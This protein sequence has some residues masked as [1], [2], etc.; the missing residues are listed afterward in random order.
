MLSTI[1]IASILC[2]RH[3]SL[4][5]SSHPLTW[6]SSLPSAWIH[7]NIVY[8]WAQKPFRGNSFWWL[9]TEIIFFWSIPKACEH[10]W[11]LVHRLTGKF[12]FC[13]PAQLL[14][15]HNS[16]EQRSHH[17]WC[18][19]D[20]PVELQLTLAREQDPEIPEVLHSQPGGSSALFYCI[21][22]VSNYW[23]QTALMMEVKVWLNQQNHIC[24]RQRSNPEVPKLDNLLPPPVPWDPVH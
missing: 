2:R 16:L 13:L 6:W 24:K 1:T 7:V 8:V 15:H 4:P 21:L 23:L 18:C 22:L 10:R 3:L 9:V 14:L 20:A 12:S 5:S 19:T 17:H 11:G